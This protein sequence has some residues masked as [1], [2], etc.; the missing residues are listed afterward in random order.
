MLT[1]NALL[2]RAEQATQKAYA[3][4]IPFKVGSALL[5]ADGAVIEG[6]NIQYPAPYQWTCAEGTALAQYVMLGRPSP[7]V[8]IAVWAE[9]TPHHHITP[10]GACRQALAEFLLP[11]TPVY[12]AHATQPDAILTLTVGDLLPHQFKL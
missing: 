2:Q 8:A 6:A 10:C 4:Y 3:P 12:M 1:P 7:I 11:E 5:L 9:N